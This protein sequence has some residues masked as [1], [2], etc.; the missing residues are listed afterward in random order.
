VDQLR[1]LERELL[2]RIGAGRND[3]GLF[4]QPGQDARFH[5]TGLAGAGRAHERGDAVLV[6]PVEKCIRR[7]FPAE[8]PIRVF[9][10]ECAQTHVRAD[11]VVFL[12]GCVR[13]RDGARERLFPEGAPRVEFV[14][15]VARGLG[16]ALAG[17]ADEDLQDRAQAAEPGRDVAPAPPVADPLGGHAQ[18]PALLVRSAGTGDRLRDPLQGRVTCLRVEQRE[19][20][21]E[22]ATGSQAT[23]SSSGPENEDRPSELR[24]SHR[25]G[26]PRPT[27]TRWSDNLDSTSFTRPGDRQ[28]GSG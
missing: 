14:Q 26:R 18:R 5:Q 8:E 1:R 10:P 25:T 27:I 23:S 21:R 16:P 15:A 4:A 24:R 6:Q 2:Q 19:A 22:D 17:L 7:P 12:R 13:F 9:R 28:S 11:G 20:L 3:D